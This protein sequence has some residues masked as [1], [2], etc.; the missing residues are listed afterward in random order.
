[1]MCLWMYGCDIAI[2]RFTIERQT[3]PLP[4]HAYLSLSQTFSL[5]EA[6]SKQK[7]NFS[8]VQVQSVW[9]LYAHTKATTSKTANSEEQLPARSHRPLTI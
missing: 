3:Q 1:M 7:A 4:L 5:C 6:N 8:K 9:H 2:F